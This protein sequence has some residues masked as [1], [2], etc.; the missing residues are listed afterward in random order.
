MILG[1]GLNGIAS[2]IW[3]ED[4][5]MMIGK[6]R[7]WLAFCGPKG[8]WRNRI[9]AK[10]YEAG[11]D[12]NFSREISP[13]TQQSLLRWSDIVNE[14]DYILWLEVKAQNYHH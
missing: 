2:I 7:P 13:K 4:M 12:I 9:Y 5:K 14:K 8:R 10:I 3:D 11:C 6:I 1:G